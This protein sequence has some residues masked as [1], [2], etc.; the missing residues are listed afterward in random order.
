MRVADGFS[1]TE[2]RAT[3]NGA[4]A[5]L[6]GGRLLHLLPIL[7]QGREG[8]AD[9]FDA[10]TVR[11][12]EAIKQ[13]KLLSQEF[14]HVWEAIKKL[15]LSGTLTI[16]NPFIQSGG[17]MFAALEYLASYY[18]GT[19]EGT[20]YEV[21]LK[22][23]QETNVLS[24]ALTLPEGEADKMRDRLAGLRAEIAKI[25]QEA[26]DAG[27]L[28]NIPAQRRF[29]LTNYEDAAAAIERTLR[30]FK[31]PL[32]KGGTTGA[33]EFESQAEQQ[34]QKE[35][36][37]LIEERDRLLAR[38]AELS[39]TDLENLQEYQRQLAD[40][41][42]HGPKRQGGATVIATADDAKNLRDQAQVQERIASIRAKMD[43]DALTAKEQLGRIEEDIAEKQFR[44][45][46]QSMTHAQKI[47]ALRERQAW[48]SNAATALEWSA[49]DDWT[50]QKAAEFRKRAAELGLEIAQ[51]QHAPRGAGRGTQIFAGPIESIGA[52]SAPV[53]AQARDASLLVLNKQAE[54]LEGIRSGV[55]SA[56]THLEHIERQGRNS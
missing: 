7:E 19:D 45:N 29:E 34:T 13:A 1:K 55:Q 36:N 24:G 10:T 38:A 5:A 42:A 41:I 23:L 25:K 31:E 54:K 26:K 56:N 49:S 17:R 15:G 33:P 51:E 20:A 21:L 50:T 22:R 3:A 43:K 40:L 2:N 14:E 35:I 4:A 47:N 8:L 39:S 44:T 53:F 12:P 18:Q 27:S 11:A 16:S 28:Q 32:S 9:F 37:R 46:L 30:L 48:F 52:R 6:F